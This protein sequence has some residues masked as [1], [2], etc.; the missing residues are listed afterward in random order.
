MVSTMM[1]LA[2]A[3]YPQAA[4]PDDVDSLVAAL[5]K[6]R[7]AIGRY[8]AVSTVTLE[9]FQKYD[10]NSKGPKDCTAEES[11]PVVLGKFLWREAGHSPRQDL[12]APDKGEFLLT[13]VGAVKEQPF[14]ET[15]HWKY[16]FDGSHFI[17]HKGKSAAIDSDAKRA[18]IA[19]DK[20]YYQFNPLGLAF[21]PHDL[22]FRGGARRVELPRKDPYGTPYKDSVPFRWTRLELSRDDKTLIGLTCEFGEWQPKYSPAATFEPEA[23]GKRKWDFVLNPRWGLLPIEVTHHQ[24]TKTGERAVFRITSVEAASEVSPGVWFPT[25]GV[26][27]EFLEGRLWSRFTFA[28]EPGSI[29]IRQSYTPA[30]FR[31]EIEPPIPLY[32]YDTKKMLHS[33]EAIQARLNQ[34][35]DEVKGNSEVK[36]FQGQ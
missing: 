19:R 4:P 17:E 34:A 22:Q 3:L 33:A 2:C 26:F 15:V 10:K 14:V 11:R 9:Q 32:D 12:L 5:G 16:T 21:L 23:V 1:L 18:D 20:L 27:R 28:V 31:I 35:V 29:K 8:E 36:P 7:G 24:A 13:P 25:K 6:M 30:D